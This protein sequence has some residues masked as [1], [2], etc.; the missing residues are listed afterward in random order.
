MQALF[1]SLFL[2]AGCAPRLHCAELLSPKFG[3]EGT[4]EPSQIIVFHGCHDGDTCTFTLPGVPPPFGNQI[5]IRLAGVDTP[6]VHGKCQREKALARQAQAVVTQLLSEA[7]Q[8][9]LVDMRR[10]KYFRVLAGIRADGQD[11][12]RVLLQQG[13]AVPYGGGTKTAKWCG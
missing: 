4:L 12:A 8:I 6:E 13:L 2:L 10:D 9:E 11:V 5:P 1:M 7:K 3:G